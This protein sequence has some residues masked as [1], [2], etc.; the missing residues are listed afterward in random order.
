MRQI[1]PDDNVENPEESSEGIGEC[2]ACGKPLRILTFTEDIPYFG[3]VLQSSFLCENCGWRFTDAF[4]AEE[5]GGAEYRMDFGSEDMSVRVVKSSFCT[6]TIPE[7]GILVEPGPASEGYI[8]NIEGILVRM[9]EATKTAMRWGNDGQK[10]KGRLV[11]KRILG[12]IKGEERATLVLRDPRGF[13]AIVSGK[14]EKV[15]IV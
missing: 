9:K 11:L 10:K 4:P 7:L 15:P 6:I 12:L 8:T 5:K 13:S 3:L 2:P 14:A 1:P